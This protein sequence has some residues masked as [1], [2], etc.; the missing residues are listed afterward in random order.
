LAQDHVGLGDAAHQGE[1]MCDEQSEVILKA[2][3]AEL[4]RR[5]DDAQYLA[6]ACVF[7]EPHKS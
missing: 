1:V 2:G 3:V 7:D 6:L 4:V 5:T